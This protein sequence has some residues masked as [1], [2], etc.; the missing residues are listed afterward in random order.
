MTPSRILRVTLCRVSYIPVPGTLLYCSQGCEPK[1]NLARSVWAF[2][3]MTVGF[4][5]SCYQTRK[6]KPKRNTSRSFPRRNELNG[7]H[8]EEFGVHVLVI[9]D[10]IAKSSPPAVPAAAAPDGT[11]RHNPQAAAT[12]YSYNLQVST[13]VVVKI[14]AG[15]SNTSIVYLSRYNLWYSVHLT[16]SSTRSCELEHLL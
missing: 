14:T 11:D 12:T 16:Y 1:M 9:C 2:T 3:E 6:N 4:G 15:L 5:R 8:F 13:A 7:Q 10:M